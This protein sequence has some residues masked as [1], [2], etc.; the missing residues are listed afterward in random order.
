MKYIL[1][2]DGKEKVYEN[3]AAAMKKYDSLKNA[4]KHCQFD[5]EFSVYEKSGESFISVLKRET[6]KKCN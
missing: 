5:M 3:S 2:I 4:G 1:I 6:F